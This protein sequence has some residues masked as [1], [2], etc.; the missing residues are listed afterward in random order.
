[1]TKSAIWTWILVPLRVLGPKM[2]VTVLEKFP[3]S[4]R[5]AKNA[6]MFHDVVKKYI[7]YLDHHS[8]EDM[9]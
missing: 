3:V 7:N 1:M 6:K 9:T 5:L 8:S 4:R 2:S